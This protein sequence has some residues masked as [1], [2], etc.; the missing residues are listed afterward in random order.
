MQEI[1]IDISRHRSKNVTEFAG[2]QF[3]IVVTVCDNARETCPVFFGNAHRLHHD[4]EDPA[5]AQGSDEER[6]ASFRRVRDELRE[7]LHD[8]LI[9]PGRAGRRRTQPECRMR[10]KCKMS[11]PII[12]H[13]VPKDHILWAPR[14]P[15]KACPMR[16]APTTAAAALLSL[17]ALAAQGPL[18]SAE[19]DVL[20]GKALFE[21]RG[22][23]ANCH[24][25]DTPGRRRGPGLNWIGC[26]GPRN[27]CVAR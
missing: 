1:G 14:F 11:F 18:T 3:E 22:E 26:C 20:A 19:G 10:M 8:R 16:S 15:I 27:R 7:Y 21:G 17:V 13:I 24:S 12:Q 4:F 6:L 23:C 25:P 2:Q 5:A 9:A